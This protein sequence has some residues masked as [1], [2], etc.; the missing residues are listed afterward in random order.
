MKKIILFAVIAL[1]FSCSDEPSNEFYNAEKK[2]EKA[3]NY[4]MQYRIINNTPYDVSAKFIMLPKFAFPSGPSGFTLN[5]T[6]GPNYMQSLLH[7]PSGL[8]FITGQYSIGKIDYNNMI[9]YRELND[10]VFINL[11]DPTD[12]GYINYYGVTSDVYSY[13]KAYFVQF[14]FLGTPFTGILSLLDSPPVSP[15]VIGSGLTY[16]SPNFTCLYNVH[17][18]HS[19]ISPNTGVIENFFEVRYFL[20][21][22]T[23]SLEDTALNLKISY[24]KDLA[25]DTYELIITEIL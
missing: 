5:T 19:E 11:K 23:H 15:M 12:P 2:S 14:K 1:F 17:N 8:N 18:V 6:Y 13:H 10:E 20:P 25:N 9:C 4:G 21:G 24:Q 7:L 16:G 3:L 22:V